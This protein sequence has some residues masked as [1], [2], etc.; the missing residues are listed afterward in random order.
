MALMMAEMLV[1]QL[2]NQSINCDV[3]SVPVQAFPAS[4][5]PPMQDVHIEAD[6]IHDEHG[7]EH[8]IC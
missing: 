5:Y 4:V 7:V 3:H 1:A 2:L 8:T 6:P